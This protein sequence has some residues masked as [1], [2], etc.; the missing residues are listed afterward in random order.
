[1]AP[2][3]EQHS[4][5]SSR[6][7]TSDQRMIELER[8][9]ITDAHFESFD[10]NGFT[11]AFPKWPT[12]ASQ[13]S[14]VLC[15]ENSVR[16]IEQLVMLGRFAPWYHEHVENVANP[17]PGD[18]YKDI[19]HKQYLSC[20]IKMRQMEIGKLRVLGEVGEAAR[21][22]QG[23]LELKELHHDFESCGELLIELQKL[24]QQERNIIIR[25]APAMSLGWLLFFVGDFTA[26]FAASVSD[27]SGSIPSAN[28]TA[29]TARIRSTNLTALTANMQRTVLET[30][31]CS[32][33][34]YIARLLSIFFLFTSGVILLTWLLRNLG[35][36]VLGI[37]ANMCCCCKCG[38]DSVTRFLDRQI[39]GSLSSLQ[40]KL[41]QQLGPRAHSTK[42][43]ALE[44]HKERAFSFCGLDQN[45]VLDQ[46]VITS[47]VHCSSCRRRS[48]RANIE[49]QEL[50][51]GLCRQCSRRRC[52]AIEAVLG[53]QVALGDFISNEIQKPV[54]PSVWQRFCTAKGRQASAMLR[55]SNQS[56]LAKAG[57]DQDCNL[58]AVINTWRLMVATYQQRCKEAIDR[59]FQVLS[60]EL[61]HVENLKQHKSQMPKKH[62]PADLVARSIRNLSEFKAEQL[63]KSQTWLIHVGALLGA[64]SPWIHDHL[65]G[66][67]DDRKCGVNI[68]VASYTLS[69]VDGDSL[70]HVWADCPD[71][72]APCLNSGRPAYQNGSLCQVGNDFQAHVGA[73]ARSGWHQPHVCDAAMYKREFWWHTVSAV[74]E[75]TLTVTIFS[76][77]L[78]VLRGYH[79]RLLFMEYFSQCVPWLGIKRQQRHSTYGLLPHFELN[80]PGN[81]VAWNKIRCFLQTFQA[82]EFHQEQQKIFFV[83]FVSL[84]L[85][86]VKLVTIMAW[87]SADHK[88]RSAS[89]SDTFAVKVVVM[90]SLSI[91]VICTLLWTGVKTTRMQEHGLRHILLL[92]QSQL[93]CSSLYFSVS[94]EVDMLLPKAF[95]LSQLHDTIEA[96]LGISQAQQR[97]MVHGMCFHS[98]LIGAASKDRAAF[99][100]KRNDLIQEKG[101]RSSNHV[102]TK[103]DKANDEE[104]E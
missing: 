88:P 58:P 63:Y 15:H 35:K 29:L 13:Q 87:L 64:A 53:L 25:V 41:E 21:L 71:L 33:W 90:Q 65:F 70:A 54:Q 5:L 37:L 98:G 59:K 79:L 82:V 85:V 40:K 39:Y 11:N 57:D 49:Q 26:V 97:I 83:A 84:A 74:A 1:M 44:W 93:T 104:L 8:L 43:G 91:F 48:P 34:C 99:E 78:R 7:G 17:R 67:D 36:L 28:L 89:L 61:Q 24:G 18:P 101:K 16:L 14:S 68:T 102:L 80:S 32:Y 94:R 23:I 9:Q 22:E 38:Q 77:L 47:T 50:A 96:R 66:C 3:C 92:K 60:E 55:V 2:R 20:L 62:I 95:T 75:F 73:Y 52:T 31:A 42:F 76:Q 6:I 81:I 45:G 10:E 56:V 103:T 51:G 72:Y 12:Y 30:W 86:V 69:S 19:K 4:Q 27:T 100:A 46:S